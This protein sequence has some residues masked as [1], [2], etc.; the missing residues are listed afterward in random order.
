MRNPRMAPD[1]VGD[2]VKV[3]PPVIVSAVT[4]FGYQL[5]DVAMGLTI[6]YTALMIVRHVWLYWIR[7][8]LS[9]EPIK[10]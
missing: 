1:L 2:A 9:Q 6:I 5:S 7:P 8:W 10:P 3:A 4:L